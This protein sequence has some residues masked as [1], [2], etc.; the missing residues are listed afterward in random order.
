[1]KTSILICTVWMLAVNFV[2]GQVPA[3]DQIKTEP[4]TVNTGF[5]F[6]FHSAILN[7]DRTI[8]IPYLMAMI[9]K[10]KNILFFI[11]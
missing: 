4:V 5:S 6:K 9:I 11:W 3:T 1:M 7:E 10:R 8:F 2:S